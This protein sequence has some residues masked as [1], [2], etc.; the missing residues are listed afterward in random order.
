MERQTDALYECY[1]DC[2]H[3]NKNQAITDLFDKESKTFLEA[4]NAWLCGNADSTQLPTQS[5]YQ[6]FRHYFAEFDADGF[7]RCCVEYWTEQ[8]VADEEL[9][10]PNCPQVLAMIKECKDNLFVVI[11]KYERPVIGLAKLKLGETVN[12]LLDVWLQRG[13]EKQ[14]GATLINAVLQKGAIRCVTRNKQLVKLLLSHD[15]PVIVELSK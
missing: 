13:F 2:F 7:R 1:H 15:K 8:A 11:H 9:A 6:I 4:P 14:F 10:L 5:V 3:L 12:E